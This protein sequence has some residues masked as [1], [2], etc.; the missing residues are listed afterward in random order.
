M[1]NRSPQLSAHKPWLGLVFLLV[2]GILILLQAVGIIAYFFRP[3]DAL[4]PSLIS[5]LFSFLFLLGCF[6]WGIRLFNSKREERKFLFS[7]AP[8]V[9]CV[10]GVLLGCVLNF[11]NDF[12]GET[13]LRLM[14][15]PLGAFTQSMSLVFWPALNMFLSLFLY[16]LVAF[17]VTR[18]TGSRRQGFA[19]AYFAVLTTLLVVSATVALISL[20]N[21]FQVKSPSNHLISLLADI[22]WYVFLAVLPAV[23][24]AFYALIG[25][26]LGSLLAYRSRPAFSSDR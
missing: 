24:Q 19:G 9:G 21:G 6:I 25:G 15:G 13:Q 5:D 18:K 2:V 22:S 3:K 14:L 16:G 12:D 23:A 20:Y 1:T 11:S 4:A 8:V 7:V 26:L 17:L 10:P